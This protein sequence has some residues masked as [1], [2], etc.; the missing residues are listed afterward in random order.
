LSITILQQVITSLYKRKGKS[1]ISAHDLEL[2]ASMELRWFDPADA[3]KVIQHAK[4]MGLLKD[5]EKG[6]VTNF[7]LDSVEIPFGFKPPKDLLESM[8]E[9]ESLFMQLVNQISMATS[10][11]PEQ[12]IADLNDKQAETKNH[13]TLEVLAL[14]YGKARDVELDNYIPTIKSKLLSGSE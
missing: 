2:L 9:E 14:L 12:I 6:M 7:N 10:L 5:T 8:T 11:K 4:T 13:F 3:R 1:A